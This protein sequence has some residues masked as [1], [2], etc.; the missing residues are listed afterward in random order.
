MKGKKLIIGY[1]NMS[2]ILTF[3][4]VM[5]SVVGMYKVEN[6][7]IALTCLIIAGVCDMFDGA[8]ARMCK[9]TEDEKA[10]GVQL[11]SLADMVSFVVFPVI[12]F[13]QTVEFNTNIRHTIESQELTVMIGQLYIIMGIVRLGWFNVHTANTEKK[14]NYYTGLPVTFISMILPVVYVVAFIFDL[15]N[16]TYYLTMIIVSFLFVG[17]FKIKKMNKILY[18]VLVIVAIL[19]LIGIWTI[20]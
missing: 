11:D 16:L 7:R 19:A 2:V 18:I 15:C 13:I 6:L 1:W 12:L 10:F 20:L 8:V 4:G 5:A 14:A 9:R 17:N 3:L